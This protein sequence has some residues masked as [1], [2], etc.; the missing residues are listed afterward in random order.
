[1]KRFFFFAVMTLI[2]ITASAK[3]E[4]QVKD[5]PVGEFTQL[6][7]NGPLRVELTQSNSNSVSVESDATDK[8]NVQ[9]IGGVLMISVNT[10]A[11]NGYNVFRAKVSVKT[12]D[13]VTFIN[14]AVLNVADD[15][16]ASAIALSAKSASTIYFRPQCHSIDVTADNASK[17][18]LTGN[19]DKFTL[20]CTEASNCQAQFMKA[21][22]T[23]VYCNEA[24]QAIVNTDTLSAQARSASR[25][26]YIGTPIITKQETYSASSIDTQE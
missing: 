22:I 26:T 19:V 6:V 20:Q 14:A 13:K 10:K 15:F 7:V 24:S 12:L 2:G 4:I 17:I 1:M 3:P 8:V 9:C 5:Y 21:G 18:V 11:V 16:H 25:I 23:E